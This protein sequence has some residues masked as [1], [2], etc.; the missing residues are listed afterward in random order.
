MEFT[1]CVCDAIAKSPCPSRWSV[2]ASPRRRARCDGNEACGGIYA[3]I[4]CCLALEL[5]VLLVKR[6]ATFIRRAPGRTSARCCCREPL[7]RAGFQWRS[8]G[9]AKLSFSPCWTEHR[10]HTQDKCFLSATENSGRTI[11]PLPRHPKRTSSLPVSVSLRACGERASARLVAKSLAHCCSGSPN[12]ACTCTKNVAVQA[13]MRATSLADG[14]TIFFPSLRRHNRR[15]NRQVHCRQALVEQSRKKHRPCP[16]APTALPDTGGCFYRFDN[17]ASRVSR[18]VTEP[19]LPKGW[20]TRIADESLDLLQDEVIQDWVSQNLVN[21]SFPKSRSEDHVCQLAMMAIVMGDVNAV[22]AL[23]CAHRRQVLTAPSLDGRSLRHKSVPFTRSPTVWDVY[24]DDLGRPI[25][26]GP[27]RDPARQRPPFFTVCRC[28]T[29][30][31][32]SGSNVA[33]DVC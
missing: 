30:A 23:Q 9:A 18:Q 22:Y 21:T 11:R 3:R 10:S 8:V 27:H 7:E 32:K 4:R 12:V 15:E 14:P 5:W 16:C 31:A 20:L 2:L 28:P 25:G 19:R 6:K 13:G 26:G 17:P 24:I 33:G 1:R 29:N